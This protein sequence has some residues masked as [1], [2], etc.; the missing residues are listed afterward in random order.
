MR[1]T[2]LSIILLGIFQQVA[3]I[4]LH[5]GIGQPY[6]TIAHAAPDA[7]PGDTLL[8][9][10]GD[11]VGGLYVADLQGTAAALIYILAAPGELVIYSCL[12]YTSRCV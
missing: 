5:V 6:P 10:A 3:A 4:T 2:I 12:L 8:V 7:D 1:T 9:H 11:Y